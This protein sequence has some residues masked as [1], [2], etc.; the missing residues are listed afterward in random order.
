[1]SSSDPAAAA[2]PR[3]VAI[4]MDGNGR[5]AQARGFPRL[6][7]HEAGARSV[8]SAI[9]SCRE[10]GIHYLT[11][12]AFSVENW[13]RPESE[14]NGLITLLKRF[15]SRNEKELHR[16]KLRLRVIGRIED[17]PEDLQAAL[18][19][20]QRDTAAYD[21][22][23][24]ILAL[25]YSSRTELV[26]ATQLIAEEVQAGTLKPEA[27]SEQTIR[28]HLYAPDVP[29]PDLMIRTSGEMRLSNFLL[30]QLS[31]SE[32]YI[33]DVMWPDFRK[34]QFREAIAEYAKR[35]RRFGDVK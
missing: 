2:V 8:R 16:H 9:E 1:M 20:A 25:S 29:D 35:K 31:Y 32:F 21:N 24:L 30:W 15:L 17:F 22:G 33:T 3:H 5:W 23:Q 12:Y 18:A 10:L 6:K 27:I 19:Q 14:I 28:D 11:L 4:I 7:G 26:R 34:D 13:V